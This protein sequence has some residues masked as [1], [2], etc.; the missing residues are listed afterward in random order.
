M[1]SFIMP[2]IISLTAHWMF[3]T[4]LKTDHLPLVF[5]GSVGE[6]TGG[7]RLQSLHGPP[8]PEPFRRITSFFPVVLSTRGSKQQV[9]VQVS[10]DIRS[11]R[12]WISLQPPTLML[13]STSTRTLRSSRYRLQDIHH[14]IG[15]QIISSRRVQNQTP[16]SHR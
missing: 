1:F 13:R 3:T 15:I 16:S 14:R 10:L 12:S 11:V 6:K 8:W 4:T 5:C 9:E 2:A 7:H